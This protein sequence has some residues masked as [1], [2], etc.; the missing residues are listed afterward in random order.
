MGE[1]GDSSQATGGLGER[2]VRQGGQPAAP[3][4]AAAGGG[5]GGWGLSDVTDAMQDRVTDTAGEAV[6]GLRGK[7]DNEA[8]EG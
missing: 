6:A 3:A 4:T 7:D 5:A 8:G 2:V 1:K